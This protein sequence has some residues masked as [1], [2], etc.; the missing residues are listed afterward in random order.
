[1]R[2]LRELPRISAPPGIF[3]SDAWVGLLP[4]FLGDRASC[5]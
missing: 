5:L 3:P 1:M 4:G 2:Q